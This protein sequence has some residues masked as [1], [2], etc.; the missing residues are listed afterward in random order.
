M[1]KIGSMAGL[2]N[3]LFLLFFYTSINQFDSNTIS[4][5]HCS[6]QSAGLNYSGMKRA[7]QSN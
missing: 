3:F 4:Y 1:E 5:I 7:L 2:N 6:A